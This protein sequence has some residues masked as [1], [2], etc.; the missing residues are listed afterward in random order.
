METTAGETRS[1]VSATERGA[2][3][4]GAKTVAVDAIL[5]CRWST[6]MALGV[7]RRPPAARAAAATPATAMPMMMPDLR[8]A[9]VCSILV[10]EG[11]LDAS[12]PNPLKPKDRSVRR[13]WS[14]LSFR[15]S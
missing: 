15:P 14:P 6:L 11:R 4:R 13:Q 9:I 5:V 7:T 10:S 8:E 3:G 1:K 2:P 12:T